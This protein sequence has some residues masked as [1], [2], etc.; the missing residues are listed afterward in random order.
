MSI[1]TI[2]SRS[3]DETFS[4]ARDLA[5]E[6]VPGTVIALQGELGAGKTVFTKGL[7]AGLSITEEITSPTFNLMERY[8]GRLPLYHFDLYRID[9]IEEFDN[10]GFQEI[11]N[12]DGV[13]VI[14]WADRA[15]ALLPESR[16]EI[17]ISYLD[18]NERRITIERPDN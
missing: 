13:S 11:W 16:I 9:F 14:E 2:I 18:D 12:G 10:L 15:S 7:G 3:Y 17:T 4:L 8:E 1:D 6:C 5:S